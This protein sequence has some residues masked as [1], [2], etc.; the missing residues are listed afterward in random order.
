MQS[1]LTNT[2]SK[3]MF[4]TLKHNTHDPYKLTLPTK[5][6]QSDRNR[7]VDRPQTNR[8]K[9][10]QRA[11]QAH[12]FD[13]Y[14]YTTQPPQKK[15]KPQKRRANP[16]KASAHGAAPPPRRHARTRRDID[17][18]RHQREIKLPH[19][20]RAR[21]FGPSARSK[22][23]GESGRYGDG[24]G[25]ES[26]NHLWC[27]REVEARRRGWNSGWGLHSRGRRLRRRPWL[28]RRRPRRGKP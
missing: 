4:Y 18:P 20:A 14:L 26:T 12:Q 27:R 9:P 7:K 21:R 22:G 1:N 6:S 17:Q 15:H 23:R 19:Q 5:P 2:K 16:D 28:R 13:S 8:T 11:S 24:E 10:T 25:G 3:F